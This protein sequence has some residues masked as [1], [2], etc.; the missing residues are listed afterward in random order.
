MIA[1]LYFIIL[2]IAGILSVIAI[3]VNDYENFIHIIAG[4]FA[5]CLWII[6]GIQQYAGVE[7]QHE[8][9]STVTTVSYT[10]SWLGLLF[11]VIGLCMVIYTI[12]QI[13]EAGTD[14]INELEN[15]EKHI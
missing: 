15:N 1:E 4:T 14:V 11:I 7:F 13:I 8:L 3:L 10:F 2:A 6:L 5:S 12:V 9:T